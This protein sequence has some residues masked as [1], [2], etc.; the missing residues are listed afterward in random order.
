MIQ[1]AVEGRPQYLTRDDGCEV[2]V[3]SREQYAHA[4]SRLKEFLLREGFAEEG[5]DTL[6][7]ALREIDDEGSPFINPKAAKLTG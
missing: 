5:D 4:G 1:A 6:D 7:R 2:V 3:V